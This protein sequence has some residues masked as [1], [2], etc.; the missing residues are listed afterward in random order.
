MDTQPY[1]YSCCP[2]VRRDSLG[3]ASAPEG[4]GLP[5]VPFL[6]LPSLS[7]P[8][9]PATSFYLLFL[10]LLF[11]PPIQRSPASL[12]SLPILSQASCCP[13]RVCPGWQEER[14]VAYSDFHQDGFFCELR[15]GDVVLE[16]FWA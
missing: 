1:G 6:L 4:R 13:Q 15:G 7:P 2:G 9:F 8:L 10:L 14:G 11:M 12:S 3:S 5:G 16:V